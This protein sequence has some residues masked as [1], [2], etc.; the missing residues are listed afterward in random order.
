MPSGK[1]KE[2][3]KDYLRNDETGMRKVILQLFLK[4]KSYTTEVV[5]NF[6]KEKKFNVTQ[7]GVSAMVGLMNTKLGILGL[8]MK[9]SR[10]MYFLKEGCREI[11]K[12]VLDNY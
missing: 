7:K 5:Y 3:L 12:S 2:R 1:V 6:L 4:E 8:D 11:L 10:N 9:K